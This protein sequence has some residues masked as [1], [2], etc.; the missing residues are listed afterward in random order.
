M[1][2]QDRWPRAVAMGLWLLVG[3]S[4]AWWASR[5]LDGGVPEA[6]L[7]VGVGAPEVDP[8]LVARALGAG[9]DGAAVSAATAAPEAKARAGRFELLGVVRQADGRGAA[10]LA[11]DGGAPKP[12]VVGMQA[13][14]GWWLVGLDSRAAALAPNAHGPATLHLRLPAPPGP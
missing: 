1:V 4:L 9:Q 5:L 10:L 8:A 7:E 2:N 3:L 11:V 6:V 14:P 13:A 12:V